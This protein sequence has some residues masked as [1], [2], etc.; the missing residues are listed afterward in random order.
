[1]TETYQIIL[2][3][4]SDGRYS[5]SVPDIDGCYTQGDNVEEAVANAKDPIEL[6]LE[7]M[8]ERGLPIP[9]PTSQPMNLRIQVPA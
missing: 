2:T 7:V 8:R 3:Q 6:M 5:V 4:E 9:S 1:M